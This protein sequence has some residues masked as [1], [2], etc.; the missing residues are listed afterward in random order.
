MHGVAVHEVTRYSALTGEPEADAILIRPGVGNIVAFIKTADCVPILIIAGEER[1]LIHAGWKG[2]ADGIIKKSCSLLKSPVGAAVLIGP[3]AGPAYYEVG[4][5]VIDA[6]GED[7]VIRGK[8]E[9]GYLLSLSETAAKKLHAVLPNA[10]LHDSKV[11]TMSNTEFH[12]YRRNKEQ[13]GRN[14]SFMVS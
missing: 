1:L 5:D 12:S 2:L 11:C 3:A 6:L 10:N 7:A 14:V 8:T 13:S 9:I 4:T